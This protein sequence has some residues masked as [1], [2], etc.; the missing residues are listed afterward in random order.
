M[1]SNGLFYGSRSRFFD[2]ESFGGRSAGA[3]GRQQL[4]S[5]GNRAKHFEMVSARFGRLANWR[6]IQ[7]EALTMLR[8]TR[9]RARIKLGEVWLK[10]YV[11]RLKFEQN[12]L[13]TIPCQRIGASYLIVLPNMTKYVQRLVLLEIVP[14]QEVRLKIQPLAKLVR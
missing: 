3:A 14:Y 5:F 13:N 11:F 8:R 6:W 9:I 12:L 10:P 2:E 7:V 1:E 4:R